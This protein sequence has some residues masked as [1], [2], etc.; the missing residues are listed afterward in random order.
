MLR[1]LLG[2]LPLIA[3]CATVGERLATPL[4][5]YDCDFI[6]YSVSFTIYAS[7]R[8]Q[9]EYLAIQLN[10]DYKLKPGMSLI[11]TTDSDDE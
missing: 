6:I 2:V 5:A 11:C 3:S 8:S 10:P 4:H 9:A 7:D 1:Y